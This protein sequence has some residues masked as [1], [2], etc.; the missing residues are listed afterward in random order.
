M[1]LFA[2]LKVLLISFRNS[3]HNFLS[4]SF[5]IVFHQLLSLHVKVLAIFCGW[6][7]GGVMSCAKLSN[8]QHD[9]DISIHFSVF[10]FIKM[11]CHY[12]TDIPA[13]YIG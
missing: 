7:P 10:Y 1:V 9:G 2:S 13:K 3:L 8:S 11:Y 6:S 4:G 5:N 12:E